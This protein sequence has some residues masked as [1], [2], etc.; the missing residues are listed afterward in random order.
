MKSLIKLFIL[1]FPIILNAQNAEINGYVS[2]NKKPI[3]GIEVIL[4]NQNRSTLTNEKGFFHFSNLNSGK[5][6]ILIDSNKYKPFQK[7]VK[8]SSAKMTI[9]N[10]ELYEN[11][12]EVEEVV[13]SSNM[14][15]ISKLE[16]AAP[17]E[18]YSSS[19]FR[20][21]PTPSVFESLQNINGIRPQLNCN[22]C[23][24]GDI[25]INGLEG[26]YTMVLIDGMPIVSGLSTVYGLNGIP[27]SLIDRIEVIKGPASTLYGSEAVGGLINVITKKPSK[28]KPI[29]L[30]VFGTS[31]A[32]INADISNKININ[33]KAISLLGINYYNYQLPVDNNKDGFTDITLQNRVSIFNKWNFKRSKNRVFSIAGRYVYENR[34][35]GEMNWNDNYRG[36]DSI[37]GESIYTNRW[38]AFGA[39]Q[40]PFNEKV[41]YMFSANG[42]NQDSYYG[43]MKFKAKQSVFFNQ[44]TWNKSIKKHEF[45]MG[46]SMRYTYYDDNTTATENIDNNSDTIN[47]P[48]INILPGF[49]IQD[50]IKIKSIAKLLFGIRYDYHQLHGNIFSPR[51]N[52]KL[53][54]KNQKTIF[55]LGLGNGYRIANVFTEDHAALTGARDVVF[56]E[57]LRPETSWNGN[58]NFEQRWYGNKIDKIALDFSLFYTYFY[59]KILPDY[60]TNVNQIIYSNLNGYAISKGSTINLEIKVNKQ[61][62]TRIGATIVDLFSIENNN[63]IYP[64]L[65]E[66]FSGTWSF[67]YKFEKINLLIDYTGNIYSPMKLPLLGNLDPRNPYSPWY[68]IQNIKVA[69]NLKNGVQLYVGVK[70]LLNW[71]PNNNT[72]FLIAR[73]QDPFDKEVQFDPNGNPISTASNPYALTFDPSYIY[74]ANQGIRVFFGIKFTF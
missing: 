10:I 52:F 13:I 4:L 35:G 64:L 70:N 41:M 24:T 31:W 51:L 40:L 56:S 36:S 61:I 7:T 29:S 48:S 5:H 18:V 69:H 22:I 50:E 72:A 8:I 49:F 38:E 21:N 44:L 60:T 32:E 3:K 1:F 62:N 15:E 27:Q 33:N 71:T 66:K 16:C 20:A 6:L 30:E 73:P 25:H 26:P 53:N 55:R 46:V 11:I 54:S 65:T 14:K 23:N 43:T 57:T 59:N 34:W 63:K 42:H 17:V 9:I 68:S 12:S 45:L 28:A 58:I 37:Y 67:Q 19:F 47:K 74:A 39:Y 2:H